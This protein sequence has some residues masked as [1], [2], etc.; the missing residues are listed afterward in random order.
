MGVSTNSFNPISFDIMK[1]NAP[2]VSVGNHVYFGH[3]LTLQSPVEIP[4]IG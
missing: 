2:G 1:I 4:Q 3:W